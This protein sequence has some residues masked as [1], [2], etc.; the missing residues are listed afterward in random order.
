MAVSGSLWDLGLCDFC[1]F[2]NFA[3]HFLKTA[4][5]CSVFP[6][7]EAAYQSFIEWVSTW[8]GIR[9]EKKK[10]GLNVLGMLN[11]LSIHRHHPSC[12]LREHLCSLMDTAVK[13]PAVINLKTQVVILILYRGL[14]YT[15]LGKQKPGLRALARCVCWL[16]LALAHVRKPRPKAAWAMGDNAK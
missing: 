6:P 8:V 7:G 16:L 12:A 4:S 15:L 3:D 5:S 1:F 11:F 14:I 9:P 13:P 2:F 10:V